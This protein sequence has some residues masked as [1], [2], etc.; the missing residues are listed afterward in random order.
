MAIYRIIRNID[1]SFDP[2]AIQA[3]YCAY[4]DVCERLGLS[5]KKDDRVTEVVARKIIEVA[6]TGE[7]NPAL[8]RDRALQALGINRPDRR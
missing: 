3:M 6:K 7:R 8:L 4:E 2:E 5:D 1:V